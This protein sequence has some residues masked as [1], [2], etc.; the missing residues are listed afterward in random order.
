MASGGRVDLDGG[1]VAPLTI[2]MIGAGHFIGSHLCEKLMAETPHVVL[3]VDIYSNKIRHLVNPPPP[4]LAGRIS[5]HR[6]NIKNDT[7]LEGL[8][9]MADLTINLAAICTPA[10]YNTRSLDTIYN[11]FID[12]LPV[13]RALTSRSTPIPKIIFSFHR[14]NIKNDPRLEGLVKMADLRTAHVAQRPHST[15]HKKVGGRWP[16]DDELQGSGRT[17]SPLVVLVPMTGQAGVGSDCSDVDLAAGLTD[18]RRGSR[19]QG[20]VPLPLIR[21]LRREFGGGADGSTERRP[22][23]VSSKAGC[24]SLPAKAM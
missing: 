11:N 8:V 20:W 10:D 24:H 15:G 6:L 9:K 4:H 16:V 2:C 21:L 13:V 7:R 5:F 12:A 18:Q 22:E 14:L 23:K 1:V 3:A 19:R 17:G